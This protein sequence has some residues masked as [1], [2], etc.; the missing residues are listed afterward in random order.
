MRDKQLVFA[1]VL[2]LANRMQSTYDAT[3]GELTLKQWLALT[4]IKHLPQPV[5]SV[6]AVAAAT[7]TTHQNA[8]KLVTALER[9]GYLERKPSITD[10][11]ARELH[12]TPTAAVYFDR[13]DGEG[14]QLL[15]A[16]FEGL[17]Q[18]DVATC[19]RVLDTMSRN[20]TGAGIRPPET[21]E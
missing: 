15:E 13:N 5:A 9:K 17:P 20:L 12:L 14:E 8:T 3:L 16:L 6:A 2:L 10:N 4:V 7:G 21:E 19:L 18:D 11:R 1:G